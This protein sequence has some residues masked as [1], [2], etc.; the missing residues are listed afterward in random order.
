VLGVDLDEHADEVGHALRT[1]LTW[2]G[3]RASRPLNLPRWLPTGG[4]RAARRGK[5]T[6]HRLAAEILHAVRADPNREAAL[7]R[8]LIEATDPETGRRLT[9]DEICHELV[10]F[11]L[12]G[13]DTPCGHWGSTATSRT[14]CERRSLRWAS[15]H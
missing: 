2:V 9:D 8:G 13:H 6:L 1:S 10:L 11:M 14:G 7:V 12:A 15:G 4:Q 5:N 3:D